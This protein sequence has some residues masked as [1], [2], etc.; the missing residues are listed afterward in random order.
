MA[1]REE[2]AFFVNLQLFESFP[3]LVY[4]LFF[5]TGPAQQAVSADFNSFNPFLCDTILLQ[6]I[7]EISI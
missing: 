7:L 3:V 5:L 6:V 1:P 2:V 4:G